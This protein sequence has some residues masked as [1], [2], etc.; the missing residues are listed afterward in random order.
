MIRWGNIINL[1]PNEW[2]KRKV[3]ILNTG[4]DTIELTLPIVF[5]WTAELTH[6][7]QLATLKHSRIEE[8]SDLL[9]MKIECDIQQYI[10]H[11]YQF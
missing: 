3:H 2:Q 10:F 7:A 8:N 4:V 1:E 5:E 6:V 9:K 11:N